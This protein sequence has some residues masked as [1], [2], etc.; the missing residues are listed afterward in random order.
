MKDVRIAVIGA[1]ASG[2]MAALV[3]AESGAKVTV[4]ERNS[5]IGRKMSITGNGKCN[6]TN[7][8]LDLSHYKDCDES[9]IESVFN[10]FDNRDLLDFLGKRGLL[11]CEKNGYFY[12]RSEQASGVITFFEKRLNSLNVSILCD[13]KAGDIEKDSNGFRII[14]DKGAYEYFDKVIV[15]C[16]GKAS[17]K[18]GSD[19][20]G[21]RLARK[22]GH[23]VSNTYPVLVPLLVKEKL[24]EL[25]GVRA[26]SSIDVIVDGEFKDSIFGEVQFTK[27]F[28]SGIPV[29]LSS[30]FVSKPVEEGKECILKFD[31]LSEIEDTDRFLKDRVEMCSNRSLKDFFDGIFNDKLYSYLLSKFCE[32][33]GFDINTEINKSDLKICED[34]I[35][36]VKNFKF[37]VT[38]HADYNAAQCTKGGVLTSELSPKLESLFCKGLYFTGEMVDVDG[39]CGGYNLQWAFSSAYVAAVHACGLE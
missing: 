9:F 5:S 36:F 25:E 34:F 15:G 22:F 10:E 23:K 18:T 3:C 21:F 27:D 16:G 38:G 14:T 11:N 39:E 26:K 32:I 17:P 1:G 30:R 7:E 28:L 6:I 2:L 13:I 35:Y 8:D 31:F 12:P 33:K 19:G 29:F 20:F 24:K 37:H 4:F